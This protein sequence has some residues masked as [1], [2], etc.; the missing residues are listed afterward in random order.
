MP[1]KYELAIRATNIR[2]RNINAELGGIGFS[3]PQLVS[4]KAMTNTKANKNKPKA[5]S[6]CFIKLAKPILIS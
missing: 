2:I 3:T 6:L 1:A 4:K 5:I